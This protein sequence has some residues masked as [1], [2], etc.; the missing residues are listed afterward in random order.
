MTI[1]EK[2]K[3]DIH[4]SVL[5][6]DSAKSESLKY[7]YSLI[8]R[9]ETL[10]GELKE[11][12]VISILGGE[13]KRK[14]EALALF[15]QGRRNDLAAK[16]AGEIAI[17]NEYLPQEL[18]EAELLAI[19]KSVVSNTDSPNFGQVMGKVMAEAKGRADGNLVARLVNE[20]V[21][22]SDEKK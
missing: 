22:G 18:S 9:E 11:E 15:S 20:V 5:N 10:K 8:Q 19:I 2:I 14:K 21:K 13:M 3:N 17:L 16:E 7:L 4:E 12:A 6:K 1:I